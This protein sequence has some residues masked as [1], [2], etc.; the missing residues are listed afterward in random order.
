MTWTV[1]VVDDE[2]RIRR[3]VEMALGDRG[4]HVL[5]AASA[6]EADGILARERIDT[7]VTDLQLP[8]RSGLDLLADVLVR[9]P[10]LPVILITAFGTVESAVEAIKAG[11]FD[12]VLK[13]F[14][15][16]ELESLVAQ[17]LESS[18]AAVPSAVAGSDGVVAVS[19]EM[20]RV[21]TLV[22]QVAGAP[23]TVLVTGETGVGKEVVARRIHRRSA[24][25][26]R[27]FV[28]VNC[29]AI[30]GELLEAELFGAQRG[31][32]TGAVKDR[33][34][35]FEVADGGTLF[36]DEIGDMPLA[37]QP[38]LLRVLQEGVVERLGSTTP[39]KVD[40]RVVAATHQ[41]LKELVRSGAFREDL[42]YR[43]DVFPIEVPPLRERPDDIEALA[44]TTL[45]EF[46]ER[47]GVRAHLSPEALGQLR[48]HPWPGNVRELRNVLER[49]VLLSRGGRLERLELSPSSAPN[50]A[51]ASSARAG[52]ETLSEAVGRAETDAIRR[53]LEHTG[54]NKARAAGL[55]GISVRTLFYKIEKLQLDV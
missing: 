16:D 31:A 36:L 39:R 41:D 45:E 14:S 7:V 12:Y 38:K 2:P 42:F 10:G 5:T 18:G 26:D 35:K 6:E 20:R 52:V 50:G 49:A 37:L 27:A 32:Y 40:V 4:Y 8:G 3:I 11:A 13:P 19:A 46:E 43:I 24:R 29:A 25:R 47:L 51:P 34:G 44:R 54:G 1:L 48:A 53:A 22:D 55:L 33:P 15:V 17:A 28:A 30:P 21:L 9:H 23:T